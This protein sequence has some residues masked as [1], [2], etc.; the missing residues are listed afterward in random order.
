MKKVEMN[1]KYIILNIGE[2]FDDY[3]EDSLFFPELPFITSIKF[4]SSDGEEVEIYDFGGTGNNA[5]G[6]ALV[7]EHIDELYV[8]GRALNDHEI[9][10]IENATEFE[11]EF[12]HYDEVRELEANGIDVTDYRASF[13]YAIVKIDGE[14]YEYNVVDHLMLT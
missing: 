12:N 2:S 10:I 9:E 13:I 4:K 1:L 7:E 14:E 8:D 5:I 3:D 11:I 6:S